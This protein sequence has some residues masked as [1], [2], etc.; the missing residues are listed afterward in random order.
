MLPRSPE[1][2]ADS[3]GAAVVQGALQGA[4]TVCQGEASGPGVYSEHTPG[5]AHGGNRESGR[6][7][8]Y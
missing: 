8:H 3:D 1:E 4:Q 7:D 2:G 5:E 6:E